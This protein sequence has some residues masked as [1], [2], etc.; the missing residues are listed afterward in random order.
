[1]YDSKLQ[2]GKT[3]VRGV[4]DCQFFEGSPIQKPFFR[5]S[6][7]NYHLSYLPMSDRRGSDNGSK[8]FLTKACVAVF[9]VGLAYVSYSYYCDDIDCKSSESSDD[10][11]DVKEEGSDIKLNDQDEIKNFKKMFEEAL[12]K[13]DVFNKSSNYLEAAAQYTE[14][15]KILAAHPSMF[16]EKA[17]VSHLLLLHNNRSAFF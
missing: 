12:D 2:K 17:K 3:L 5:L 16:S 9:I 1:M 10:E 13:A 14:A 8:S 6:I 4:Q 11:N 15:L 7:I